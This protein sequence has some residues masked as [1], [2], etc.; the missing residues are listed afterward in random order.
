MKTL[1]VDLGPRSYDIHIA[2]GLL[3]RVGEEIKKVCP[4]ARRLAVVTDTNVDPLYSE[5]VTASM[6]AA[7]FYTAVFTGPAGE[8]AKC[9]AHLTALWEAMLEFGLTRTAGSD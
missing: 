9:P 5:R 2:S 4:K 1:H 8:G 6:E 3:C 7:G